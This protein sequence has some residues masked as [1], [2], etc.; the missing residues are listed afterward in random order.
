VGVYILHMLPPMV[1]H[2]ASKISWQKNP[3]LGYEFYSSSN[4]ELLVHL[5]PSL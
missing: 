4:L 3:E 1:L 2:M 5:I